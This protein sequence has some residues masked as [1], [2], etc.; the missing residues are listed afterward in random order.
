MPKK[1]STI[2]VLP[3]VSQVKII[4]LSFRCP[5]KGF[6]IYQI[7]VFKEKKKILIVH[8]LSVSTKMAA[9]SIGNNVSLAEIAVGMPIFQ[10]RFAGSFP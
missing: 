2:N 1:A 7:S 10:A 5:K 9:N 8:R 3:F 4:S 6:P